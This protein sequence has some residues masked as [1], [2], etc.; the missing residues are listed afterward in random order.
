MSVVLF[1]TS[2]IQ[3]IVTLLAV[4]VVLGI[5]GAILRK[6]FRLGKVAAFM[7]KMVVG[8]VF[9]FAVLEMVAEALPALAMVTQL[10]YIL[11]ML[12]IVSSIL[13]NLGKMGLPIPA[14]LKKD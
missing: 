14:I 9:G 12:S 4:D 1:E 6:E 10:A 2:Q 11:I 5:V 13:T 7:K 8:Y 3:W